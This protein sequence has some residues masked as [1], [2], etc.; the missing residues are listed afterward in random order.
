LILF[1]LKLNNITKVKKYFHITKKPAEFLRQAQ[2]NT[3]ENSYEW[4]N[5]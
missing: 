3:Y 2:T 5:N 4:F 1:I